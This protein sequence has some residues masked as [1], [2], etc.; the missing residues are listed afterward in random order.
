M[1]VVNSLAQFRAFSLRHPEFWSMIGSRA[2]VS[3]KPKARTMYM[4]SFHAT[5]IAGAVTLDLIRSKLAVPTFGLVGCDPLQEYR[6]ILTAFPGPSI[7]SLDRKGMD[8]NVKFAAIDWIIDNL[9]SKFLTTRNKQIDILSIRKVIS[10]LLQLPV[11]EPTGRVVHFRERGLQSGLFGLIQHVEDLLTQVATI[12]A[13]LELYVEQG[14]WSLKQLGTLADDSCEGGDW[15]DLDS[16]LMSRLHAN[17]KC[18]G[19][20]LDS[21]R[22][23]FSDVASGYSGC[24]I[25]GYW[26]DESGAHLDIEQLVAGL[27]QPERSV[28]AEHFDALQDYRAQGYLNVCSDRYPEFKS[29]CSMIA[30]ALGPKPD[31]SSFPFNPSSN[32]SPLTTVTAIMPKAKHINSKQC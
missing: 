11:V 22:V 23:Y 20:I 25:L 24:D 18:F 16:V 10:Y 4:V 28:K 3:V 30:K 26:V 21:D 1:A 9:S 7:L 15:N 17:E 6:S 31:I 8:Q 14:V 32:P 29:A 27:V 19:M 2:A 5:A 13:E 12:R